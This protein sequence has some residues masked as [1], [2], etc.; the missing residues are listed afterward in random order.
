MHI[1]FQTSH[2]ALLIH[3]TFTQMYS[4]HSDAIC[5]SSFSVYTQYIV[6][7]TLLIN[8]TR[9]YEKKKTHEF[10]EISKKKMFFV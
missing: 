3:I 9:D 5:Y 1:L 4:T 2:K 6:H 7:G 10:H 8:T